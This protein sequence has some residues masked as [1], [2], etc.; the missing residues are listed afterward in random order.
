[1]ALTIEEPTPAR[2]D[3][4]NADLV[5]RGGAADAYVAR[6]VRAIRAARLNA[7]F[8][9]SRPLINHVSFL[10]P[11]GSC[12]VYDQLRLSPHTGMPT[13]R[14][15]LRVAIDRELA[16]EFLAD[17]ARRP[18]PM[19]D[20][21]LARRIDYYGRLARCEVLPSSRMSVDL[22]RQIEAE[23]RAELRVTYDRFD[24]ATGLFV[25]YT[26]LLS[27]RDSFWSQRHVIVDDN[28][29]AA[30]TE[31]FRR[32]V[33]RFTAHEAEVAFILLS[34]LEGIEVEDVRRCRVGP[35][36][37][38]GVHGVGEALEALLA[39]PANAPA[40]EPR[41]ILCFPEDRAG[42][43]LAT[44]SAGDPLSRLYRDALSDSA[45]EL[46]DEMSQQLGYKVAKSRKFVC[47]RPLA[48]PLSDLCRELGAPSV[49]RGV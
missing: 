20:G 44:H 3:A 38:P 43:E 9:P 12:G 28:D 18:A 32:T 16:P 7:L 1:M 34:Q 10:G 19:P 37:M 48:A 6:L 25:R 5:L 40:D 29:L 47:A 4:Q 30:P 15:V 39:A 49:V 24:I 2:P 35:M 17:V 14:E 21:S 27:Q 36:L 31:G 41:W 22:R 8:P 33:G 42:V 13:A 45:R 23:S 26:I 11:A 46:V